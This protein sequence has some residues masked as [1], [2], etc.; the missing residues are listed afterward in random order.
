MD[1]LPTVIMEA[2]ATGLPVI[3]TNLGGIP[4]MVVEHETGFLVRPGDVESMADAIQ[5]VI[6][7]HSLAATLGQAGYHRAQTLFSIENNVRELCRLIAIGNRE[8]S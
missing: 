3:S 2:M 8:R 7:D 4:E 1:N 6:S 5:E